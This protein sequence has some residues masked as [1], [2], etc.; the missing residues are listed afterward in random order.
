MAKSRNYR[1]LVDAGICPTCRIRPRKKDVVLCEKCHSLRLSPN[2]KAKQRELIKK[3]IENNRT[4]GLCDRCK[5]PRV[6]GR[7]ECIKCI[8]RKAEYTKERRMAVF[9]LYGGKCE[10]C[11]EDKFEFL[12]IDHVNGNGT[13][14]R[15]NGFKIYH[16]RTKL[17]L[18][19]K[20]NPNYRVL[21]MNCN[22]ALGIHGFCPHKKENK[23]IVRAL[24]F[25]KVRH[26]L[27][28]NKL[29]QGQVDGINAIIDEW[30]SANY[31]DLRWLSYIFATT[32]HET[33][34][35]MQPIEEY[36][37]GKGRIYGNPDT[38]TGKVYYGRG[39]VQLTWASNYKKMGKILGVDLYNKPEIALQMDVAT[40]IMFEGMTTGKSF[41][42]D[43]TG[44]QLVNYFNKKTNDPLNA[45]RI[46][47]GTDK[48]KLIE[49]YHYKFLNA[50]S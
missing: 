39:F 34:K 36:G 30:E 10:C 24:F 41:A 15:R 29:N 17:L 42:G 21:C 37:K 35:T 50:L 18:D 5:N 28:G 4:L 16:L 19:G 23:M 7:T 38:V 2:R 8:T 45:R 48:A 26:S 47:N 6:E 22:F 40:K 1:D 25:N 33:N 44:K 14:E 27:F 12:T 31:S 43:F 49:G 32:Y 13:T 46:I 11:G 9:N 3:Y 20:P